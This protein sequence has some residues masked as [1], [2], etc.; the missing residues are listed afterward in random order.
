MIHIQSNIKIIGRD[1][2]R[3][4]RAAIC[5]MNAVRIFESAHFAAWF[6][7]QTFT[8]LSSAQKRMSMSDLITMLTIEHDFGYQSVSRPWYKFSK[9]TMG[10]TD[11]NVINTYRD[12]FDSLT[13]A[14]LSAHIGHEFTHIM[15]FE[16]AFK[17]S[18][19]RN[20]SA[21]YM[22]GNYIEAALESK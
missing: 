19:L 7:N 10:W 5:W 4:N 9:S 12:C 3:A 8:Q 22:I 13:D 14:E 16:H 11:N 17:Y 21:P 2:L 20:Q 15:G 18:I 1:Q 6:A